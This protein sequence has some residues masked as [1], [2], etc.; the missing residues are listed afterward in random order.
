MLIFSFD[1]LTESQRTPFENQSHRVRRAEGV[2]TGLGEPKATWALLLPHHNPHRKSHSGCQHWSQSRT[3]PVSHLTAS[4]PGEEEQHC[5]SPKSPTTDVSVTVFFSER[6]LEGITLHKRPYT[7][8]KQEF[9]S[10]CWVPAHCSPNHTRV[11]LPLL[12]PREQKCTNAPTIVPG[13]KLCKLCFWALEISRNC[14]IS[15]HLCGFDSIWLSGMVPQFIQQ[16]T[17]EANCRICNSSPEA[18]G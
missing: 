18:S 1:S 8:Q 4:S 9:R 10:R 6:K 3:P 17:S 14:G 2:P 13:K 15:F 5:C 16:K 12:Q 7:L 11:R